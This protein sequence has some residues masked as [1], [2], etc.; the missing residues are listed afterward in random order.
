MAW[1]FH[2]QWATDPAREIQARSASDWLSLPDKGAPTTPALIDGTEGWIA[3]LWVQGMGLH[4][5]HVWMQERPDRRLEV[6]HWSDAQSVGSVWI[7]GHDIVS[8]SYEDG[9]L[10]IRLG[11]ATEQQRTIYAPASDRARFENMHS[12][13][14]LV[15]VLDWND[16]P[17]PP[18][19][20][21]RHGVVVP[22]ALWKQLLAK[23]IPEWAL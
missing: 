17:I 20:E 18:L 13:S 23:P 15:A 10:T 21:Q 11:P 6:R 8:H 9:P 14:G 19:A 12:Q 5:D 2:I 22:E 16:F 4:D 7:F 3:R 1:T